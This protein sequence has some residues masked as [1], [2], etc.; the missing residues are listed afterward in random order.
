LP[1]ARLAAVNA[2]LPFVNAASRLLDH[3]LIAAIA[4]ICQIRRHA[5]P[6]DDLVQFGS[7]PTLLV[8]SNSNW[9]RI[10]FRQ[11]LKA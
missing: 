11:R 7:P 4:K 9:R 2:E 10:W 1:A 6:A 5:R 8:K 3:G